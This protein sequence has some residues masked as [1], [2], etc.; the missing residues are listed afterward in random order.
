MSGS[1]YYLHRKTGGIYRVLAS[2][3]ERRC[4]REEGERVLPLYTDMEIGRD[5]YTVTDTYPKDTLVVFYEN[6]L[7]GQRWARA[8]SM[9]GDGRFAQFDEPPLD[10]LTP[11]D[12][13]GVSQAAK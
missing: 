3:Y 9:F 6:V 7:T 13:S 8:A 2:E 4:G 10:L 5:W 12:A 11:E 1:S